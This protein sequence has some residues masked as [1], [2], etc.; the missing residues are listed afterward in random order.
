[1]HHAPRGA[2]RWK[3]ARYV[4]VSCNG[5]AEAKLDVGFGKIKFQ[6]PLPGVLEE[7]SQLKL[8]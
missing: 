1:V 2:M 7:N 8:T 3:Y 5:P 6:L 4:R